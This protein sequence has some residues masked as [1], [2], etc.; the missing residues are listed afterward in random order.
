[1]ISH[2]RRPSRRSPAAAHPTP[3]PI[4]APVL[5]CPL[6]C[7]LAAVWAGDV[8]V[9][10]AAV[11]GG[12]DVDVGLKSLNQVIE[13]PVLVGRTFSMGLKSVSTVITLHA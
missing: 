7:T 9:G 6:E 11:P 10:D 5:N 8:V 1:M 2:A 12:R 4:L 3:M 13:P